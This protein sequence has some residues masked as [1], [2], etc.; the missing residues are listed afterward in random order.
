[1]RRLL[2]LGILA[3]ACSSTGRYPARET[4]ASLAVAVPFPRETPF[5]VGSKPTPS[6]PAWRFEVVAGTQ[7]LAT[8]PGTVIDVSTRGPR[9]D[10]G[11]GGH[12]VQIRHEDGTVAHYGGMTI[13]SVP[14][15]T[16]STGRRL[17]VVA[18]PDGKCPSH[19]VFS[20]SAANG[21]EIPIRFDG[22]PDGVAEDVSYRVP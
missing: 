22:F 14:G 5:R 3:A 20:I 17:G 11:A 9:S 13:Y 2:V 6:L 12:H 4:P 18:A 8:R 16:V 1:M 21:H 7:V 19:A 15:Q 10:C